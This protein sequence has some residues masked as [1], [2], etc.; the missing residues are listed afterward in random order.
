MLWSTK[1]LEFKSITELSWSY[2]LAFDLFRMMSS[3]YLSTPGWF[4][5]FKKKE[6]NVICDITTSSWWRYLWTITKFLL[7]RKIFCMINCG[8]EAMLHPTVKFRQNMC[9]FINEFVKKKILIAEPLNLWVYGW[10]KFWTTFHIIFHNQ[11][12]FP[13]L[14]PTQYSVTMF[15]STPYTIEFT[16]H[17]D[18]T[19]YMTDTW[20][21]I[22]PVY[23]C[24][25]DLC[26]EIILIP[27]SGGM[28]SARKQNVS[29]GWKVE[30]T[31]WDISFRRI[32]S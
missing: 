6:Y 18:C 24:F 30:R 1:D 21:L 31:L 17:I 9:I 32:T 27:K 22:D 8:V 23:N 26:S 25:V 16:N 14:H 19:S 13:T 15:E 28:W 7:C 5:Q 10:L 20:N 4:W 2:C 12:R 3:T 11:T 29:K